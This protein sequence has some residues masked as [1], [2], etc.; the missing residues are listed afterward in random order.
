MSQNSNSIQN[1][2]SISPSIMSFNENYM[3]VIKIRDPYFENSW[4]WFV[5]IELNSEPIRI[6]KSPYHYK[7]SKY[8]SIPKTIKEHPSMCS[9]KS[10]KNVKDTSSIFEIDDD[11]KDTTLNYHYHNIITH[12]ICITGL[13][14]FY[15]ITC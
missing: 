5:D 15:F 11:I 1:E 8:I 9:M 3:S 2:V 10:I 12:T 4:G 6:I 13:A 7:L 14:L